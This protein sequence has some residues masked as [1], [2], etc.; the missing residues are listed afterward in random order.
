MHHGKYE[1]IDKSLSPNYVLEIFYKSLATS[2]FCWNFG[3]I[4][5][6]YHHNLQN[7]HRTSKK[8]SPKSV[9][10]VMIRKSGTKNYSMTKAINF[11][12]KSLNLPGF[13]QTGD[14]SPLLGLMMRYALPAA[15]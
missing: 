12:Y 8:F 10:I 5:F 2:H 4:V 3:L 6:F 11:G 14:S 1:K 15:F 13:F 7:C 9:L